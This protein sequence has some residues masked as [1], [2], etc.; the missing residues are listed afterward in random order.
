MNGSV[1]RRFEEAQFLLNEDLTL[2][3]CNLSFGELM[4]SIGV[5]QL[6]GRNIQDFLSEASLQRF[7][8][9]IDQ[10]EPGQEVLVDLVLEGAPGR[11]LSLQALLQQVLDGGTRCIQVRSLPSSLL[12]FSRSEAEGDERLRFLMQLTTEGIVIHENGIIIDINQ[13]LLNLLG[14]TAEEVLGQS[15][16]IFTHPDEHRAIR[17]VVE[18]NLDFLGIRHIKDR[19]G[20]YRPMEV[21]SRS[22][23]HQGKMLR[24]LT[25]R[26]VSELQRI[27]AE[28]QRM[29]AILEASPLILFVFD[30]NQVHYINRQGAAALGYAS[31]QEVLK[32]APA[33]L[34]GPEFAVQLF[35]EAIPEAQRSGRWEGQAILRRKDGVLLFVSQTLLAH[36]NEGGKTDFFSAICLDISDEV[37]AWQQ[38]RESQERLKYFMEQSR[39]AIIINRQGLILDYNDAALLLFGYGPSTLQGRSVMQLIQTDLSPGLKEKILHGLEADEEAIGVRADGSTF[40]LQVRM[41]R[42]TYKGQQVQVLSLLDVSSFKRTEYQLKR[43][44]AMLHAATQAARMGIWE[45]NLVTNMVTINE[46]LQQMAGLTE[47]ESELDFASLLE[48]IADRGLNELLVKIRQH[49][50]GESEMLQHMVHTRPIKGNSYV[51][52]LKGRLVRDAH[53]VPVQIIGTAQDITERYQMEE[54]LRKSEALLSAVLHTRQEP[55]WAVDGNFRLLS[56]NPSCVRLFQKVFGGM[57]HL[58]EPFRIGADETETQKWQQRFRHCLEQGTQRF[59]D[60][61]QMDAQKII[62]EFT[63]TPLKSDNGLTAG[64]SVLGRDITQEKEFEASLQQAREAAEQ[65]NR[66]KGQFIANISHEI[67]TPMNAILGFTD[68]LLQMRLSRLQREYLEIVR[69]SGESLLSLLNDLLDLAKMEAARQELML[70]E[71]SPRAL[72]AEVKKAFQAKAR[73][74]GLRLRTTVAASV[75]KRI[76]ADPGRLRQ[77]L[78]NL[79]SNAI[80][81][82]ERGT[83]HLQMAVAKKSARKKCLLYVEVSD[84][85]IGIPAEMQQ[86]IFEPFRQLGNR[87]TSR[88]GGTGLGLSIARHLVRLMKGELEV[89]SKPGEGSRFY[90][91]IPVSCPSTLRTKSSRK[92]RSRP[93]TRKKEKLA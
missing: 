29:L 86:I 69:S 14:Y 23:M 79:V 9:A 32:V 75:P 64:V 8:R 31:Q 27:R 54:A 50:A 74:Q 92:G 5:P 76:V 88:Y 25:I 81:F 60:E 62:M 85:G 15:V 87:L 10:L 68:M 45:W 91:T 6:L 66:M 49:L 70:D 19:Q 82:S 56:F 46:V 13:S 90:F 44:Q 43:S 77:V 39:E 89:N 55:I 36:R 30:R 59:V 3:G 26:D 18:N 65:A 21:N 47:K 17:Y 42:R 7:L 84:E 24:V 67:R 35:D 63:A 83:V 28:E 33:E 34:F 48:L 41:H 37:L 22:V 71:C 51:L 20:N 93:R 52:E 2:R 73:M 80:K 38:V 40:E 4:A 16:F 58:G 72:V 12:R 61:L 1:H 11:R 57:P 53:N 78:N